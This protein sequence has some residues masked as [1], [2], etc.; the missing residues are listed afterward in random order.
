MED[1]ADIINQFAT[2]LSQLI[3]YIK[4]IFDSFTKKDKADESAE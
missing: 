4:Q 1:I 3:S 2:Y